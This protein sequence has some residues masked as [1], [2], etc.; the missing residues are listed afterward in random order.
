MGGNIVLSLTPLSIKIYFKKWHEIH[1]IIIWYITD[2]FVV[3]Q[4][5]IHAFN[6]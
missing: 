6:P 2:F 3:I 1:L 5:S 4:H